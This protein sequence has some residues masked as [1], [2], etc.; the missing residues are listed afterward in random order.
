MSWFRFGASLTEPQEPAI[1][2]TSVQN[3]LSLGLMLLQKRRRKDSFDRLDSLI[4]SYLIWDNYSA[5]YKKQRSVKETQL[6]SWKSLFHI[7]E[8]NQKHK[9]LLP[10]DYLGNQIGNTKFLLPISSLDPNLAGKEAPKSMEGQT[11][12]EHLVSHLSDD[13]FIEV[14]YQVR[15]NLL[16][17]SY[18]IRKDDIATIIMRAG[19]PFVPLVA[20][21]VE[22]TKW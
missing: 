12:S 11:P 5:E 8:I 19:V 3:V 17:G 4:Y 18:D 10:S 15:C 14:E 16:H 13:D 2:F 20:W 7:P 9:E 6:Q 22:N 1:T 21:M